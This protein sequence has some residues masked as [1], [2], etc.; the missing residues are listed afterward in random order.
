MKAHSIIFNLLLFLG[1]SPLLNAQS[2]PDLA[3]QIDEIFKD[4]KAD[5]PGGVVGIV[6]DGQ[7]VFSKAYGLASLEY[8]VP[9]TTETIFNIASVS[10]QFTAF[11]MILLEQRGVLSLDSDI[12][13]FIPELPDFGTSITIRHLLHHISGLRNFQGMLAMA[14]WRDG[15]AMTNEDLVRFLSKQKELNFPVG[16]EYLYCNS[17]FS[18]CT[19][20]V[21]RVTGK[22]FQDW[23][24]ENIF[25]PLGMTN[26]GYREDLEQVHKNTA[27]SYD[28]SSGGPFIQ[29]LKYWTY[30]GNGNLYT[31]VGDM[32]K[33][34]NN[35]QNPTL[36]GADAIK[37][38][39]TAGVLNNGEKLNYGLG[40][41]VG[42]YKGL[43]R[44]SH[45][46]SVGGYRSDMVYLPDHKLGI[47]I[48]ANYSGAS[49]G[50]KTSAL[51]DL[52][53]KDQITEP[54]TA[55]TSRF[56][57]NREAT[58]FDAA[59]FKPYVG[60]YQVEGVIVELSQQG[61]QMLIFAEG[62]LPQPLPLQASSDTSFFV[63][64]VDLGVMLYEHEGAPRIY[65]EFVGNRYWG[66]KVDEGVNSEDLTGTYYSPELDT[67]YTIINKDGQIEVLHQ[68]HNTFQLY[69]SSS[70]QYYGSAYFFSDVKVERDNG[71]QVQGIRVS[72]GRVRNLW[73]EKIK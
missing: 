14:G 27:T 40:I 22:T 7:L 42:T 31:T 51:V 24:K 49:P 71:G 56:K 18:L 38:L 34:I 37:K 60:K 44:Y 29:P 8:D 16:E 55:S 43:A 57:V 1:F 12:R 62:Q 64:G 5:A 68:R 25:E 46:G 6:Q 2:I 11:S 23:T 39:T 35:L 20:I 58:A 69:A 33:W 72:N 73:F 65:A 4:W 59:K 26:S 53:L 47:A 21:E 70:N 36:G 32:A 15:E 61:D 3:P 67:R 48:F 30:M 54:S 41:G 17:G 19:V 52:I 50:S 28:G 63:N 10:K 66:F 13:T 45:G 9:N